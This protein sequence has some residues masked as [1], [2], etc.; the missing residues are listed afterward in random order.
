MTANLAGTLQGDLP[1]LEKQRGGHRSDLS[2]EGSDEGHLVY[3]WLARSSYSSDRPND[4]EALKAAALLLVKKQHRDHVI[5]LP[6]T[7]EVRRQQGSPKVAAEECF[8]CPASGKPASALLAHTVRQRIAPSLSC[9][10]A[11]VCRWWM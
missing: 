1:W 8:C 9:C 10:R 11:R 5:V 7:A 3:S 2:Y 4:F 6:T